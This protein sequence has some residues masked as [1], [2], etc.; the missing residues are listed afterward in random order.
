MQLIIRSIDTPAEDIVALE[1]AARDGGALPAFTA[2]AHIDLHLAPGL[3]RSYSLLNDPAER[4]RYVVAV[5]KDPAS[6]GGSRH[7]HES[8]RAGQ[9]ITVSEPRNHFPLVEDAPLVALVAG[10]IGIT[11]LL[12]MI[13][14]LAALGRP[15]RLFYSARTRAKCA[16]IKEIMALAEQSRGIVELYVVDERAGAVPDIAAMV[17]TV[18]LDAHLYCCGP[19]PMLQAF[20]KATAWRPAGHVH[21]EYFSASQE[22]AVAGG[23]DVVLQR[24]QRTLR[25]DAG[26]SILDVLLANGVDV[27]YACQEGVCGACQTRVLEGTPDHRDSYLSPRE[28]SKGDTIMLCCS[29]STADKLVLDL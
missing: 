1:L 13:R 2:G 3:V 14:R 11:P 29:G 19:L 18:A 8:L 12:S 27:S 20:E 4:L 23:Y 22:A 28:K 17:N 21:V 9:V 7:V 10:G 15:W 26:K 16:Y 24:S 6:R 25:I 5:N